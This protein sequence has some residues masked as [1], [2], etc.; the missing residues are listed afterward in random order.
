MAAVRVIATSMSTGQ[1]AGIAAAFCIKEGI[2]PRKFD[3]KI[4][5]KSMIEYG[6]ALDKETEGH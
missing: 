5:R 1:A 6:V 3:G 4:V 2:E